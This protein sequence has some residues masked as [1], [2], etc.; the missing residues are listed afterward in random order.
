MKLIVEAKTGQ[1]KKKV[2]LLFKRGSHVWQE[3]TGEVSGM[4]EVAVGWGSEKG[5]SVCF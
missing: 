2:P 3:F 1:V 5:I 4:G